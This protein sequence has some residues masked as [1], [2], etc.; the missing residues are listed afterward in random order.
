MHLKCCS[1]LFHLCVAPNIVRCN[2][3]C[4]EKN[5]LASTGEKQLEIPV[6]PVWGYI[7]NA[8]ISP[9]PCTASAPSSMST[10]WFLWLAYR[11]QMGVH[12]ASAVRSECRPPI[13]SPAS[14]SITSQGNSDASFANHQNCINELRSWT[15]SWSPTIWQTWCVSFSVTQSRTWAWQCHWNVVV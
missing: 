4:L 1:I 3:S 11:E 6:C 2:G 15:R 9:E 7:T 12:P 13:L 14:I 10:V 5:G 8:C